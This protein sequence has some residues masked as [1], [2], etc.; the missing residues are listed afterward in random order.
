MIPLVIQR[1][2]ARRYSSEEALQTIASMIDAEIMLKIYDPVTGESHNWS[3]SDSEV[4]GWIDIEQDS[5]KLVVTLVEER[6]LASLKDLNTNLGQER[7][8]DLEL[9][10]NQL[11]NG[12]AQGEQETILVEYQP[13]TYIVQPGDNIVSIS[14]RIGMPYWKLYEV[15]PMLAQQGLVVGDELVV[16]PQDD[17]LTLPVVPDKR[18]EISI[19]SQRMWTYEDGEMIGEYVISTGVPS[20]PTLPGIFQISS[21]ELN[22]YASIWDLY[23][24]HFMGIYDAVPGLTN[25]IHGLPLLSGGRRL[26]ADVLGNP[27]SYGCI[28][29]DLQ[30]A[31][32][33]YYWA[34]DGVVVEIRE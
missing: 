10:A 24:P 1:I 34:D 30:A 9:A 14:F 3:P 29:L 26:W 22:A 31:E 20:S 7:S 33:L 2:P 28:I 15:N 17:M 12:F 19:L 5:S 23:M 6:M 27:A 18:I 25:G 13:R 8:I 16:P 11:K 4:L 21:H 32:Q